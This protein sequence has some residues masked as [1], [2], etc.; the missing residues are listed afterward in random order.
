MKLYPLKTIIRKI[1]TIFR[2]H[3]PECGFKKIISIRFPKSTEHFY[4]IDNKRII[5]LIFC[6]VVSQNPVESK[7]CDSSRYNWIFYFIGIK[8]L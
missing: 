1:R 6:K 3:Q 4:A 2:I 5:I 8:L 7:S